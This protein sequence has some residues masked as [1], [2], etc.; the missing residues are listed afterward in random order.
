MQKA[1]AFVLLAAGSLFVL[2]GAAEADP[3]YDRCIDDSRESEF[4]SCG[5]AWVQ[6]EDGRLNA[7]WRELLPLLEG[8]ERGALV[9]EQRAWIAFNENSCDYLYTDRW[10]TIGRNT[11]YPRC[12]A[13]IIIARTAQLRDLRAQIAD[14][15]E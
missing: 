6:R 3:E 9:A 10:G 14:Q 12:R 1:W 8:V 15:G 11:W 7:A 5:A 13:A 2:S 4:A